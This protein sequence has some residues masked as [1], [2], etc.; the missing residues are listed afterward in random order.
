[1][2]KAKII[3]VTF[4]LLIGT[5]MFKVFYRNT[6]KMG[7]TPYQV[8]VNGVEQSTIPSKGSYKVVVGCTRG[9][10]IWDYDAWELVIEGSN[11]GTNQCYLEFNSIANED[12]KYISTYIKDELS[13]T[14]QGSSM[15]AGQIVHETFV[16]SNV[17]YDTGYRYEGS[18]PNNYVKFNNELWRIIGTFS[19][20]PAGESSPEYLTKIIRNDSIGSYAYDNSSSNGSSIWITQDGTRKASLNYLLNDYYYLR[21]DGTDSGYCT[22]SNFNN[23]NVTRVCD[24]RNIGINTTYRSMIEEVTWNIGGASNSNNPKDAYRLE[25]G[26]SKPSGSA[27]TWDG[28]IGLMYPSDFGFS[29]LATSCA[30]TIGMSAYNTNACGGHAWLLNYGFEWTISP[31]GSNASYVLNVS[32]NGNLNNNNASYG[33]AVRP[34]LYLKSN[35]YIVDG[36]GSLTNPYIL[37]M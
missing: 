7:R 18:N 20:T 36:D 4:C 19:V 29:V 11:K 2:K 13:G 8:Y 32:S 6:I 30:R 34:V 21:Q 17:T 35:V 25:R 5:L 31:N 22:F 24:Y 27:N 9:D 10:A 37:M 12:K 3:I 28:Y 15:N 1:M 16:Q 26:T 23:T 33:L 14:Q